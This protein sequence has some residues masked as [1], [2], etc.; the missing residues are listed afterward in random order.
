MV[1]LWTEPEHSA[2]PELEQ[3]LQAL[4]AETGLSRLALRVCINRG[5]Q[6]AEQ[7]RGFLNP[8]LEG[9]TSPFAIRDLASAVDRLADARD[10][11]ESV[12]VFG[13]YDVDGTTGAA[14]LGWV[15]RDLAFPHWDVRQPDRFKDGYGLSVKAVEEAARDGIK[16]LVTVDCGITAHEPARRACELG[17]DLIIV[18]HHQL[19]AQGL[20]PAFATVNPH[21]PDCTSGLTQLCGCG[22]AFYVA[23]GLRSRGRERGWFVA[24]TGQAEPN[25]KRHLDL[26]VIATACDMVPLTGDNHILVKHG[27]EVLR[28]TTKPGLRALMT[29]AGIGDRDVSPTHLGF[30][31]GPRINASGR[32]G[33]A[34][35]ACELLRTED[36]ARAAE[37]A[38]Q[39]EVMNTERAELQNK[40]WDQVRARVEEGLRAGKFSHGIVVADEAWHEGVVGIVA[41]RV[42]ET[43]KRPAAV[44]GL[45][46]GAGKGSVRTYRGKDVLAALRASSEALLA[47]GGHRHAAGLSVEASRVEDL[48]RLFDEALAKGD[49]AGEAGQAT[50]L[51]IEG[52]CTPEEFT[53]GSLT[54]LEKLGPFGP[55]HPEPVFA[56]QAAVTEKRILKGRHLKLRLGAVEAIWFNAA[57]RE[58]GTQALLLSEASEW[59]GVP[60]LNRFRG[61]V[62][63][64]IRVKDWRPRTP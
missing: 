16:V 9:L 53:V 18:D 32:M 30:S 19:D 47:F 54:E 56:F 3:R 17:I 8:K 42:V 49:L 38:R 27:L 52:V 20:P 6:T 4:G 41:T 2:A 43:F 58:E 50:P 33:S 12:R 48:A 23:L 61:S 25:L 44:I 63:P 14:L 15:L 59:A 57:E 13:D 45:R 46:D 35:L 39:L 62:T 31:L 34:G 60:E 1:R 64:T 36:P 28:R 55:G 21:R 10:R 24:G 40:I 29:S 22:L 37:L 5:L 11:A 7:I 51:P 26:V